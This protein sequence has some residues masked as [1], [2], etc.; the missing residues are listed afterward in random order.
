MEEFIAQA[1]IVIATTSSDVANQ[2]ESHAVFAEF[3][4]DLEDTE[5]Q[6]HDALHTVS[7]QRLDGDDEFQ[8]FGQVWSE[9]QSL[10]SIC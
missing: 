2:P 3:A 6:Y 10:L 1:V 9:D 7:R 4:Y 8:L 5:H